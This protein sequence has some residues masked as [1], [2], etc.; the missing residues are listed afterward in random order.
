M[1]QEHLNNDVVVNVVTGWPF[2]PLV[3]HDRVGTALAGFPIDRNE[4][5]LAR[6]DTARKVER[7][8]IADARRWDLLEG[9]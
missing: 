5:I 8:Q 2:I 6:R 4:H 1:L 9:L 3:D 7:T